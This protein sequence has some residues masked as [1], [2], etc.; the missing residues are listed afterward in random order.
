VA[1]H[2]LPARPIIADQPEHPDYEMR[3]ALIMDGWKLH[4]FPA[5]RGFW[6][7]QLTGDTEEGKSV[8]RT[9]PSGSRP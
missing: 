3:R 9:E 7:F 6:L 2:E 1:G 5:R 4:H 8:H